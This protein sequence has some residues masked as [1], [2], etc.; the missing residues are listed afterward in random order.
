MLSNIFFWT[1]LTLYIVLILSTVVIITLENRQ[2]AKTIAW[3]LAI[4]ALPVVGFVFF[5]IFGQNLK[6]EHTINRHHYRQLLRRLRNRQMPERLANLPEKY[7]QLIQLCAKTMGAL[8]TASNT[9]QM[10]PSGADYMQALLRDIAAAKNFVLIE[11]YII[12][13]D[14]VGRLLSDALAEK[15]SQ[16]VAVYLI[17]D[18]V[19]CWRVPQKFFRRLERAGIKVEAFMEVRFPSLTS[20]VN[21]RNHRKLC[22]I[23]GTTSYVG[24]M[25]FA[26][27]YVS[28]AQTTWY[29][30]QL[31]I[32]GTASLSLQH[33]FMADWQFASGREIP[34]SL[35]AHEPETTVNEGPVVQM[36][37]SSPASQYPELMYAL[38]WALQNARRYVYIQTPYFMPT[39]PVLQALETAALMD[40]D[41]RIMLPMRPDGKWLKWANESYFSELLQAGI[42]IYRCTDGFL[43]A[44]MVVIDDDWCTIGSSNID[45]RS[46]ENNFE[47]GAVIYDKDTALEARRFF[48]SNLPHCKEL[49][50][51]E[52]KRRPFGHKW[53]ESATR[54]MA[55]LF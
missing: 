48:E 41:V 15:A 34:A 36:L 26:L 46:F 32:E 20:K 47:V 39:E 52:W 30:L 53:A 55:P 13:D 43:H 16:G 54:I 42:K 7:F 40:V 6:K 35:F 10:L 51:A 21:Y 28:H 25:N 19:G 50:Y 23:D 8:P 33:I 44:K 38:T 29:D 18:D 22:V 31:R 4:V 2:P 11:T 24:G 1:T 12:E 17:Y 37:T 49:K 45:F 27:R 9:L 3:I 5:L 14:A